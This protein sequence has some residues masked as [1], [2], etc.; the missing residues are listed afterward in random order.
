MSIPRVHV[1]TISPCQYHKSMSIP[2]GL[3]CWTTKF[4][5]LKRM[6][7]SCQIHPIF[8]KRLADDDDYNDNNHINYEQERWSV[9]PYADCYPPCPRL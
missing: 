8:L 7:T 9:L 6:G 1:N 2:Q 4:R 5:N 3:G